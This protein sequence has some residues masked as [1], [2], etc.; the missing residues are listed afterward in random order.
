MPQIQCVHRQVCVSNV[1]HLDRLRN[2]DQ[3][4]ALSYILTGLY[5]PGQLLRG[6]RDSVCGGG[7]KKVLVSGSIP[8][9]RDGLGL[10]QLTYTDMSNL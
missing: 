1:R 10:W 3:L 7:G 6:C 2:P 8:E 9:R 5:T 4:T